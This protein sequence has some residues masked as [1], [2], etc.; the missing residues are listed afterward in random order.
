MSFRLVATIAMLIGS[1]AGWAWGAP[2]PSLV[3]SDD[4]WQLEIELHGQPQLLT[5]T[6]PGDTEPQ[7]FWYVLYTV[8]N[9]SDQDVEFYPQFDLLTD[10][11]RLSHAGVGVRRPVF[12]AVRNRYR[13]AIPLMEP[14]SMGT[15]KI[16]LGRDNARD[17]V[18]IFKDFDPRATAV[19]IF[20]GGFSNETVTVEHPMLKDAETGEP[21]QVLLRKTLRLKYQVPG[22]EFSPDGRV[23]L[24]RDREWIMR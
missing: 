9:N 22:D 15:G 19:S 16:L 3:P 2:E 17:S 18:A 21:E 6:L 23:M 8:T 20:A 10:T 5:I 4:T 24:Y 14:A 13:S 1:L 11:F 12:E 7:R